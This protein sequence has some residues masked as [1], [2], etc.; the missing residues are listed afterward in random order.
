MAPKKINKKKERIAQFLFLAKKKKKRNKWRGGFCYEPIVWNE[1]DVAIKIE[2]PNIIVLINRWSFLFF[3]GGG[4]WLSLIQLPV[5]ALDWPPGY[6]VYKE[7][8]K[9]IACLRK[10]PSF[11]Y[12]REKETKNKT[13]LVFLSQ[14][15]RWEQTHEAK[16]L[17][18]LLRSR[19]MVFRNWTVPLLLAW[20]C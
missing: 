14:A 18:D 4:G 20:N 13:C 2:H 6:Q 1:S 16:Q 5:C 19:P 15:E 10:A 8:K 11:F 9:R 3:W 17:L 12:V 7:N